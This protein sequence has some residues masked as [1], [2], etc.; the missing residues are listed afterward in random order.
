MKK[1]WWIV[2]SLV[3]LAVLFDLRMRPAEIN[4]NAYDPFTDPAVIHKQE[5]TATE[6]ARGLIS[7]NPI[8]PGHCLII[9]KRPVQRFEQLT[10][11]EVVEMSCVIRQTHEAIQAKLGPCDYVLLQKN[12]VCVGQVQHHLIWHYIPRPKN[13]PSVLLFTLRF[14]H[15]FH[16]RLNDQAMSEWVSDMKEF[17]YEQ[18]AEPVIVNATENCEVD[19]FSECQSSLKG[20]SELGD[21]VAPV[22]AGSRAMNY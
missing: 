15:P 21:E 17:L 20:C 1:R 12:G 9:P 11:E 19:S 5:Y 6:L 22:P 18:Q 16:P 7:L 14:S 2:V 13:Q 3:V 4:P 8:A 10:C